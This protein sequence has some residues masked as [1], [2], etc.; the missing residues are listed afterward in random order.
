MTAPGE[1]GPPGT[2][3]LLVEAGPSTRPVYE[4]VPARPAPEGDWILDASPGLALGAAAGDVLEVGPDSAF[5]VVRRGGNIAVH[6]SSPA[7]ANR[8]R[9]AL[10]ETISALGGRLDARGWTRDGANSLS[11]YTIPVAAGRPAIEQALT[12]FAAETPDGHWY[13]ANA[14]D[15][16]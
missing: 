16:P 8:Q 9:D 12:T 1:G 3:R 14:D 11:V 5:R 15:T 7:A 10:T 4:D 6:V 13:Y 2:V